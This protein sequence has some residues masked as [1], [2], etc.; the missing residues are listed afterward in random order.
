MKDELVTTGLRFDG[1]GRLVARQQPDGSSALTRYD[2]CGRPIEL[3]DEL[4]GRTV[5][6][7]DAAGRVVAMTRPSGATVRYE[8]DRCGRPSAV[9][10]ET[11]AKTLFAYD[12]D[13][14]LVR[15]H[16]PTGEVAWTGYD[17]VGRVVQR[18]LPGVGS[19]TVGYDGAGRVIETRDGQ[20]GHRRFRYDAASQLV[21]AIDGNGGTTRYEYDAAGR[22]VTVVDPAGGRTRRQYDSMGNVVAQSDPL[23]RTTQAGYD[24]AGRQLWQQDATGDRVCWSYDGSGRLAGLSAN[25]TLL[26]STERDVPARRVRVI[27]G[28]TVHELAWDPRGLLTERLRDGRGLRWEYDPNGAC[29]AVVH[30]D[31][32]RTAYERDA[33]GRLVAVEHQSLGRAVLQRDTWGRVAAVSSGA[34]AQRWE[35]RDGFVVRHEASDGRTTSHT[36]VDRDEAGQVTQVCREG[37]S[38]EFRYDG[39]CQ[40][41]EARR[42]DSV[43]RWRYDS[44]GRLVSETTDNAVRERAYD[45]A[46]QL[47]NTKSG[48]VVTTYEYDAAGRRVRERGPHGWSREY[49]WA[50]T[51]WLAGLTESSPDGSTYRLPVRVDA[52]GELAWVGDAEVFWDTTDPWS[53]VLQV[54]ATEVVT[55]GPLIGTAPTGAWLSPTW[56]AARSDTDPWSVPTGASLGDGIGVGAAGEL[57]LGGLEWLG[58]RVYDPASRT[59]LSTDPIDPVVGAGWAGNPYSY[60]GNDPLNAVDPLGLRPVTDAELQA[61]RDAHRGLLAESRD[62]CADNWEYIAAGAMVVAG[63]VMIATGVGG[64][65]GMGLVSAGIDTG[66]QKLT[67]GQVDWGKVAVTGAVGTVAGGAVSGFKWAAQ[68]GQSANA[69]R[70]TM[71]VNGV[72]GAAGN[73]AVYLGDRPREVGAGPAPRGRPSVAASAVPS[74]VPPGP[75]AEP[76]PGASGRAPRVS[77][78]RRRHSAS[79]LPLGSSRPTSNGADYGPTDGLEDR[80]PQRRWWGVR[81]PCRL[82]RPA[83]PRDDD[84]RA[85]AVLR[86][87]QCRRRAV[88]QPV[89][90]PGGVGSSRHRCCRQ[91]HLV[92]R[93]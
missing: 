89:E 36:V 70:T 11:G 34:A 91:R 18:H 71:A 74:A 54:G 83:R 33:A 29:R 75:S 53:P 28:S 59:F 88:L 90:H 15:E 1:L 22:V 21:E 8:Y 38:T 2:R 49:A 39:A 79:T 27:E 10:D 17:A 13:G 7:R 32:T 80:G 20:F 86:A 77:P 72:V 23:E 42:G 62:W 40:L 41:V 5:L 82:S 87:S 58:A 57:T 60:A 66:L 48:S 26:S 45:A 50:P 76:S 64:P 63:G 68:L 52:L 6:R 3:V 93:R 24:A 81:R 65:V 51:G 25:G 35:R 9:V 46:G 78:P 67:T 44:C 69:L 73:E 31:G 85:A 4:G 37:V 30:P 55:A 12:P 84:D 56:R 61:Y 43:T 16:Y 92:R 14:H 47:L 19:T